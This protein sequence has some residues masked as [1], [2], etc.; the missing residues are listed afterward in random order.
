[1]SS[2]KINLNFTMSDI[3]TLLE[4]VQQVDEGEQEIV[5]EWSIPDDK[6][7]VLAV[8]ISVGDDEF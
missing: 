7:T 1:M 6:G 8:N 2:V 4:R 3:E 5:F